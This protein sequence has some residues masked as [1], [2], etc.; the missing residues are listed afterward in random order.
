LAEFK[1]ELTKVEVI[2]IVLFDKSLFVFA[3]ES[4]IHERLNP[5]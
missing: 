3:Y 1:T 5:G 4:E 2:V